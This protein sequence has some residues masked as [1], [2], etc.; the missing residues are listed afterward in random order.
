MA[1]ILPNSTNC[2]GYTSFAGNRGN[3]DSLA[4]ILGFAVEYTAGNRNTVSTDDSNFV[5][6]VSSNSCHLIRYRVVG[7]ETQL[8]FTMKAQDAPAG[9]EPQNTEMYMY[10]WNSNSS[11]WE[12]LDTSPTPSLDT[13]TGTVSSNVSNYIDGSNDVYTLV[14]AGAGAMHSLDLYYAE[15]ETA[16]APEPPSGGG[17]SASISAGRWVTGERRKYNRLVSR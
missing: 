11:A 2:T 7:D 3:P 5:S 8:D 17:V 9:P 6:A 4:T 13:M 10:V 16:A 1:T 12:L 14:A 15:L